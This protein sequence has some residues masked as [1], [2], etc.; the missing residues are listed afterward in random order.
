[1]EFKELSWNVAPRV[2]KKTDIQMYFFFQLS[3]IIWYF[4]DFNHDMFH[5]MSRN[6]DERCGDFH[7]SSELQRHIRVI[8]SNS[9]ESS[10][11][12]QF[13]LSRTIQYVHICFI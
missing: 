8:S 2:E 12:D 10:G 1:M 3:Y 6:R 4:F 9:D 13:Y 11:R 5:F 7:A